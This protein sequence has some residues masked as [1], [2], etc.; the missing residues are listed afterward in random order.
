MKNFSFANRLQN[1]NKMKSQQ[2]D[3][4]IIGGGINGAGVAR[5]AA[6][7]GMK[8]ALIEAR[9]FASG[10]SSKSSKLIHGGIRYLEN[11]EFKL[12]FE[13]LNERTRLFEMAPHLV[14]PLRFMI[15]LYEESRVGMFKMGLGMWLY[16]ALCLFQAP[17]MHERLDKRQSVNRMPAIRT[18]NLLGSYVYSD[19]YMDDDRLVH[20]TLRSANELGAIC[21]NYVKSTGVRFGEDGKIGAVLCEDQQTKE[22]FSIS[23]RHVISTVGPWTDELGE[24]IFKDW[25]KILRPTK[26]IHLTLPKNRLPLNSAVVMAA[27]KS[28]RIVFGI[29]RHEMIIIGTTDTDFKGAPEEVM[30]TPEDVS[31]LLKI[32]DDYFPGANLKAQDIIAS[33]A[34]VRPLVNDGSTSE[35]KTSREHIIINDDRGI[36][37]VAGGKYTTYRLMCQ[38]TVEAALSSFTLEERASWGRADT[39]Q[40]LN[41]YTSMDAFQQA[42]FQAD[43]WAVET[44]HS[45]AE[46]DLLAQR[47]G[48]EGGEILNKYS[49]EWS[50]W[51]LEAAQAIDMTMCL[52]LRDFYARRVPLFLADRN[53]G[54]KYLDEVGHVFQEKLGWSDARLKQEVHDLTE[55][56]AREVEWKKHF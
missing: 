52:H 37:F 30:T 44:G 1:I 11:M 4:A 56:M 17:E 45:S 33:Y 54:V 10:T 40:P 39:T 53:H 50:Y 16:D 41:S 25:K 9:D 13:A 27:E 35:G 28:D 49:A 6:A 8:V 5:D 26:G 19:A 24:K 34:G 14:H 51:Q 55:Y 43:S 38:Q 29:P 23:A 32:T 20:E 31:Y 15:P 2:F 36:T 7:R 48:L 46:M 42:L 21:V 22:A 12:V 18:A 3:L 47:Y